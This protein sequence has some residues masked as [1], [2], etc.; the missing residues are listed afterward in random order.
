LGTLVVERNVLDADNS[1]AGN[2]LY[3]A[4]HEKKRVAVRD[5]TLDSRL[6]ED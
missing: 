2:E 5:E 6:K 1:L 4:V 3:D